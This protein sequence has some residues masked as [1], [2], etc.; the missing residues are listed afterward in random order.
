LT[1]FKPLRKGSLLGFAS[2]RLPSGL[3]ISDC[4]VNTSHGKFWAS[5]PSRPV[6]D[7]EGRHVERDGKKQYAAIL[8]WSDRETADA[9]SARVVELVHEH[10]PSAFGDEG[11]R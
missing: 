3:L 10:H 7:K 2:V 1:A 6:I 4:P 5:L 11:A 8:S 9:W